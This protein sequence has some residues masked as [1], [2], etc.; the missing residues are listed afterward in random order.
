[1]GNEAGMSADEHTYLN[2]EFRKVPTDAEYATALL[3]EAELSAKMNTGNMDVADQWLEAS[4][5]VSDIHNERINE[6]IAR[7]RGINQ[8]KPHQGADP[9]VSQSRS[10]WPPLRASKCG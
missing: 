4:R 3:R 9:S 5:Q 7:F 2:R 6:K 8:R 10:S 1:M